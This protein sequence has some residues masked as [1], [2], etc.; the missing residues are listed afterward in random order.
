[1]IHKTH[2]PLPGHVRVVFELPAS[3]WADRI[4]LVGDFN[5]WNQNATPMRQDRDGI[6]RAA[7]DLRYGTQAEFRYLIDGEWRTDYHADGQ[8][9]NSFGSENSIVHAELPELTPGLDLSGSHIRESLSRP[10][11]A[12]SPIAAPAKTTR[13]QRPQRTLGSPARAA[14]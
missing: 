3:L 1:M 4:F 13:L 5:Q 7:I 11:A 2:S 8:T 12:P 9:Y 6:W 14:A 10:I